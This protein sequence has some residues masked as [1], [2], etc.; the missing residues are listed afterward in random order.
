MCW[1]LLKLFELSV[2][3]R[4]EFGNTEEP[5]QFM[6]KGETGDWR[7]HLSAEQLAR[8]VEWEELGLRGTDLRFVY[9]L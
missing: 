3:L 5:A 4:Q 6:R 1:F 8:M 9:D 7:N 2:I